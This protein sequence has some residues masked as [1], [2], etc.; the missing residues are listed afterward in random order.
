MVLPREKAPEA[1]VERN[2]K[3]LSR[4]RPYTRKPCVALMPNAD[5]ASYE[6]V[7]EAHKQGRRVSTRGMSTEE[8]KAALLG[9]KA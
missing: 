3:R 4:W 7:E 5:S 9:K 8:L 6:V 2:T 1:K